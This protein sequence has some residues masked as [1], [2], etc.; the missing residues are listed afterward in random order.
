MSNE[1]MADW[2]SEAQVANSDF[3]SKVAYARQEY[4]KVSFTDPHS[5]PLEVREGNDFRPT[6]LSSIT[7]EIKKA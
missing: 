2:G 4:N 5:T 1:S 7:F 3:P 6:K